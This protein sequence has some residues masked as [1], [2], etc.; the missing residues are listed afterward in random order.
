M[1]RRNTLRSKRSRKNQTPRRSLRTKRMKR[2]KR[3]NKRSNTKKRMKRTKRMRRKRSQNKIGGAII[4]QP[5]T[6]SGRVVPD[7]MQEKE[8]KRLD[9]LRY[10]KNTYIDE[11]GESVIELTEQA[12]SEARGN[13]TILRSIREDATEPSADLK[14][15]LQALVDTGLE[16]T[17]EL[18][19]KG[20]SSLIHSALA[21]RVRTRGLSYESLQRGFVM[22]GNALDGPTKNVLMK[23]ADRDGNGLVSPQEFTDFMNMLQRARDRRGEFALSSGDAA[24]ADE[25][26]EKERKDVRKAEKEKKS[27]EKYAEKAAAA[28]AEL[29]DA[30]AVEKR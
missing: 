5:E 12:E 1:A 19:Q 18:R 15:R 30:M 2:T 25:A 10:I 20:S 11:N 3:S 14:L 13:P 7:A 16:L 22:N 17:L 26:A 4:W 21:G 23:L 9:A 8:T 6:P 27:H 29:Q 28:M 24:A